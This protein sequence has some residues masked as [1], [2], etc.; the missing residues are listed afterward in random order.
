VTQQPDKEPT[1]DHQTANAE[2]VHNPRNFWG[3]SGFATVVAAIIGACA[4]VLAQCGIKKDPSP[5]AQPIAIS[6]TEIGT[7]TVVLPR[8]LPP[9]QLPQQTGPVATTEPRIHWQGMVRLRSGDRLNFDLVPPRNDIPID[10][11]LSQESGRF[12]LHDRGGVCSD[13]T[14]PAKQECSDHTETHALPPASRCPG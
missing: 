6:V 2:T 11:F 8:L 14:E 5:P 10:E 12:E 3:T 4:T 13:T 9:P 7:M 1:N